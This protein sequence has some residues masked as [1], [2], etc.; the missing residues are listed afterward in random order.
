M[1]DKDDELV[2]ANEKLVEQLKR[3]T[4]TEKA[5]KDLKRQAGKDS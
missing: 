3:Q 2:K 5:L 1:S 4:D